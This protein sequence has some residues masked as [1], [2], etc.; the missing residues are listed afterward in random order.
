MPYGQSPFE[1]AAQDVQSMGQGIGAIGL[2]V[3][4]AR[5]MQSMAQQ[6][7][8]L[9]MGKMAMQ[10]QQYD[11]QNAMRNALNQAQ[12]A[13]YKAQSGQA[14][15]G[16]RLNEAKLDSSGKIADTTRNAYWQQHPLKGE[17]NPG[18]PTQEQSDTGNM[19]DLAAQT[20]RSRA[21]A[22]KAG[23]MQTI[24][25]NQILVDPVLGGLQGMGLRSV[26]PGDLYNETPGMPLKQAPFA[27]RVGNQPKSTAVDAQLIKGLTEGNI[28]APKIGGT[29]TPG[30]GEMELWKAAQGALQRVNDM[31]NH[32]QSQGALA[33]NKAAGAAS[34]RIKVR[35]DGVMGSIPSEQLDEALKNGYE[36]VQP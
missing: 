34:T 10:Q 9:A 24:G 14:E 12:I 4:R 22:G 2:Q 17:I 29:N 36:Q 31:N 5:Y 3:A 18:I 15:S 23:Q 20:A 7:Q 32:E 30:P 11:Q 35:K 19:A 28:M 26:A 27:P 33:P 16:Q 1:N 13:H 25:Q 6:R 8:A 21:L